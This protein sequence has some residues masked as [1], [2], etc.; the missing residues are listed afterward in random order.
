MLKWYVD[1][2]TEAERQEHI[3][4]VLKVTPDRQGSLDAWAWPCLRERA[5]PLGQ[6]GGWC[7]LRPKGLTRTPA[8]RCRAGY[9]GRHPPGSPMAPFLSGASTPGCGLAGGLSAR[10]T[11]GRAGRRA[12]GQAWPFPALAFI[13]T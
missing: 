6:G 11:D 5:P 1:R 10:T 8:G 13:I 12:G 3:Q 2:I 7:S 4:E 9:T